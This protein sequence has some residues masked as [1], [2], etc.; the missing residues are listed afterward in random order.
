NGVT[1]SGLDLTSAI[2]AKAWSLTGNPGTTAATNFIGTT[3]AVDFVAKTNNTERMRIL[4]SGN[5]GIGT[6]SPSE[7]LHIYGSAGVNG[8]LR[9]SSNAGATSNILKVIAGTGMQIQ[10]GGA[11]P[12]MSFDNTNL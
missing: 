6:S 5:V 9:I 10:T 12:I 2:D 4:S 1:S 8:G 3:D 7:L 11:S